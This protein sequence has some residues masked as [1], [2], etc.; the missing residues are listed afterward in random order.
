MFTVNN[1]TRNNCNSLTGYL[2]NTKLIY[3]LLY[4]PLVKTFSRPEKWMVPE[5]FKADTFNAFSCISQNRVLP[6]HGALD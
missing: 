5:A 2:L 3:T 6:E 4:H 1:I